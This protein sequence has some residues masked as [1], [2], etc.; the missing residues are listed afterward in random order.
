MD[1]NRPKDDKEYLERLCKKDPF[2]MNLLELKD[3]LT[4]IIKSKIDVTND[5][6]IKDVFKHIQIYF[7]I[8]DLQTNKLNSTYSVNSSFIK[9][10]GLFLKSKYPNEYE[11]ILTV[12]EEISK[13][14]DMER[15]KDLPISSQEEI[16]DGVGKLMRENMRR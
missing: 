14:Q 9:A 1:E 16:L 4:Y 8:V 3:Y 11:D 5:P 2:Y 15:L 12:A 10:I 7:N 6:V 13:E